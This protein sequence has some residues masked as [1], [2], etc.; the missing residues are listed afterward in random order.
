MTHTPARRLPG[1]CHYLAAAIAAMTPIFVQAQGAGGVEEMVI[2]GLRASRSSTGA[3]GLNLDLSDTPQ[4]IVQLNRELLDSFAL[5]NVNSAL[6]YVNGVNVET[7]ET[8]RTTYFVRGFEIKQM[9]IDGVRMSTTGEFVGSLDTAL[10]EK[11]EVIRGANGLLTGIGAPSGTVN[12]IRKRPLNELGARVEYISDRWNT[13]RLE[14]DFSTPITRDGR[15]AV[16]VVGTHSDED[17]WI[18][19]YSNARDVAYVVVDGQLTDNA[20]LTVGY[21][22]QNSESSSPLWGAPPTVYSDGTQTQW[23]P[24]ISNSMDWTFWDTRTK[25]AFAELMY[26]L[27]GDWRLKLVA[28]SSDYTEDSETVWYDL[29]PDRE[30]GLGMTGWPGSYPGAAKVNF[31]DLSLAGGFSLFGRDHELVVGMN[32][33]EDKIRSWSRN[34]PDTDPIW[35]PVPPFNEHWNGTEIPR[36]A[37]GPP[38]LTSDYKRV[39]TRYYSAANWQLSDTIALI[40]GLH[41]FDVETTGVAWD[42]PADEFADET[43]PYVGVTWSITDNTTV[44]ASYSDIF[45]P[46]SEQDSNRD[47]LGSAK[48]E[49]YEIGVKHDMFDGAL[50]GS[51]AL[52]KAE[53][54]NLAEWDGS[55]E[56][57]NFSWYRGSNIETQGV[58]IDFTG[59]AGDYVTLQAGY[60]FMDLVN[61]DSGGQRTYLP[62]HT[63]TLLADADVPALPGLSLGASLRWQSEIFYTSANTGTEVKQDAYALIGLNASYDID[64]QFTVALN[65]DNV[66]DEHHLTSLYWADIYAWDQAFYGEPRNVTLRLTYEW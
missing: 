48:G 27:P 51:V 39:L 16:R 14:A 21:S 54:N 9:Q 45:Q 35:G 41:Y 33:N 20:V 12:Y 17:S 53:L 13:R 5:D 59:R 46:Q 55:D 10:Y 23:D 4:A 60:S 24:S 19:R 1:R 34:V 40:T 28:S 7:G 52:Y 8:E 64:D 15:W 18:D 57:S 36:P 6:R 50:L 62:E 26:Q 3:T 47:F 31:G 29:R 61:A 11:I 37:F 58:E 43:S 25:N 38:E 56:A 44:Y 63:V 66:T 49:N 42:A 2:T 65:L 30:T 22:Y 32:R